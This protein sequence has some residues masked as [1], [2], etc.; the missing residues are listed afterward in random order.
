MK[1]VLLEALEV[2]GYARTSVFA[3]GTK[4]GTAA[5]AAGAADLKPL[6]EQWLAELYAQERAISSQRPSGSH[7]VHVYKRVK[8]IGPGIVRMLESR[9][10]KQATAGQ[11]GAASLP[12]LLPKSSSGLSNVSVDTAS[13]GLSSSVPVSAATAAS[14]ATEKRRRAPQRK[15]PSTAG[16]S[17]F[18]DPAPAATLALAAATAAEATTA[19]DA[20][21]AAVT[22]SQP[23]K[24]RRAGGGGAG[25]A[26]GVVA[27]QYV[28]RH[29]SGAWAL[30]LGL[31]SQLSRELGGALSKQEL[32]RAATP[33]ADAPLE[34]PG[35]NSYSGWSS[36][37]LLMTKGLVLKAGFPP[38]YSLTDDGW[39]LAER[40]A[41]LGAR[42]E[43]PEPVDGR[44]ERL[45]DLMDHFWGDERSSYNSALTASLRTAPAPASTSASAVTSTSTTVSNSDTAEAPYQ[46]TVQDFVLAPE[47][48]DIVLL[49]DQREQGMGRDRGFFQNGLAAR[50]VR[51]E[52]RQLALGDIV[53]IA[54]KKGS[55]MVDEDSEIVLD[56]VLER[57]TMDDLVMSIK[58]GRFAEQKFRLKASG[59]SH[60]IYLVE[61]Q[62]MDSAQQFGIESV[63]TAITQTQVESGFFVKMTASADETLDYLAAV[64]AELLA[65]FARMSIVVSSNESAPNFCARVPALASSPSTSSRSG[66]GGKPP[67][68][69]FAKSLTSFSE[70]ST[71][72]RHFTLADVWVRQLATVP[73]VS[74]EKAAA[75]AAKFPT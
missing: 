73:G 33:H 8:G 71:K 65:Q 60:V 23:G 3:L 12:P 62:S 7:L 72:N 26:S 53:W 35:A 46:P 42:I 22:T 13:S 36:M 20:D 63:L 14:A 45:Q 25:N 48:A 50:S 29:R 11:T 67:Y 43:T 17:A 10:Q 15:P 61:V 39:R 57:K 19:A 52:T 18:A 58:D 9:L 28:P 69:F 31:H 68:Y 37:S 24:R 51:F 5:T 30:L 55:L 34:Q 54:R 4:H 59:I 6:F 74:L 40:L 70:S 56:T 49:I 38:A 2:T 27:D 16:P 44:G 41:R 21:T 66:G 32:V 75:I 64:S 47:D 1:P